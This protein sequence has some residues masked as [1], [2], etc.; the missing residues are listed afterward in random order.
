MSSVFPT[1]HATWLLH[2]IVHDPAAAREHVLARYLDPL[3]AYARA[4]TLRALGEPEELVHDFLASRAA[5]ASYL[6]RWASSGIPLRRWLAN[7][8]LMHA[9]NKAVAEARRS[10][11]GAGVEPGELDRL[12]ATH[13]ADAILA[14]ERAWAVRTMAEAYEQVRVELQSEGRAAWWELFRLHSIHGLAYAQA[15]EAAGVARSNATNVH[16]SVVGRLRAALTAILLRDGIRAD[17]IERELAQMQAFLE[18]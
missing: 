9:R 18:A 1:T 12:S 10:R 4:S 7:G 14:L 2:T 13:E 5:E 11:L 17:E 3:C 16:R 15:C 8:L 6:E